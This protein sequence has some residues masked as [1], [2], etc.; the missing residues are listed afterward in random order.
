V[1]TEQWLA[2]I[3]AMVRIIEK[4]MVISPH[5]YGRAYIED[6]PRLL[7]LIVGVQIAYTELKKE[8]EEYKEEMVDL[9]LERDLYC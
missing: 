5:A 6:V 9:A 4:L 2:E 1:A 8:Y 7:K 3:R